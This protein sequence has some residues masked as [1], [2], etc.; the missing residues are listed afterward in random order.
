MTTINLRNQTSID[1]FE[2]E[3]LSLE[4]LE[5]VS[6]GRGGEVVIIGCTTRPPLGGYPPGTITWNPWIGQPYPQPI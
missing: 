4:R 2:T 5:Q 3:V 6:G 1:H